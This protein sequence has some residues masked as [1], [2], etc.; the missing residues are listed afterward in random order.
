LIKLKGKTQSPYQHY[1]EFILF[2]KNLII[3]GICSLFIG[4]YFSQLYAQYDSSNGAAN[5]ILTL[6]VEYS[7]DTPIFAILFYKDNKS[8]YVDI[9][10]GKKD[11]RKI[12]EDIKK[13]FAAFSI[14]ECVY[15]ITKVSLQYQFLQYTNLQSYQAA[16]IS[17]L[18]AWGLFF[19]L[20]NVTIAAMSLF[21]RQALCQSSANRIDT[22]STITSTTTSNNHHHNKS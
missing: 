18:I 7:I 4:A 11:P 3:A 2:N 16:M 21:R 19:I 8:R 20:I 9:L 5:S 14:T 1:R 10:T 13:L 15:S 22:G 6:L 12:K 17:S